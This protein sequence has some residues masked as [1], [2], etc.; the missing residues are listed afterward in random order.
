MGRILLCVGE[1]AK[2]PY[3]LEAFDRNIYCVEELC[4]ELYQYA[5]LLDQKIMD[6]LLVEWLEKECRCVDLAKLLFGILHKKGAL[7]DFVI[8]LFGYVGFYTKTEITVLE[9]LLKN[10]TSLTQ[11][12]R[13][14]AYADYLLENKRIQKAIAQY[15]RLCLMLPY[16]EKEICGKV[17]HNLG[18][19]YS[20]LF[21]FH[22]AAEEFQM[23]YELYER[24]DSMKQFLAAKRLELEE[25][26]YIRLY[27]DRKEFYDAQ[28]E[29]EKKLKQLHEEWEI[30]EERVEVED[31]KQNRKKK[32]IIK[33][34]EEVKQ[35]YRKGIE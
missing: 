22:Q 1:Y 16:S 14:K 30:S 33:I 25:Q 12:D 31:L 9:R 6:R 32:E 17:H 13:K 5:Y 34:V 4:H 11:F 7:S 24:K 15:Q 2:T 18:V 21:L 8:T 29:L 26:E 23:A 20:R 3:Y 35:E 19:A 27:A 10:N 28:L